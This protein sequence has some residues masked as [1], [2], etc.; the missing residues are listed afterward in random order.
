MQGIMPFLWFDTEAEEAAEFYTSVFD[1]ARI[2]D[3]RRYGEAGP[4][5]PGSVMT[6]T[7]EVRGL[8]LTAL[9]GGPDFRFNEAISLL[10]SCATQDEVDELWAKLSDG[11]AEG[12]CGWVRDRY[13][14]WWQVVPDTLG[15]MLQDADAER[16]KRVMEAMLKM[17][18][19][20]TAELQRAYDGV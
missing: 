11:G 2:L 20:E 18:K 13:G 12:Q 15:D 5:P 1:D 6:V 10:V 8:Q 17:R 16:A 3:V 4:R 14:L 19:I 9:N 7:F